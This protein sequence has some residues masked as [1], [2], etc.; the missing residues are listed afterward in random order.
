MI[1]HAR[2]I[3]RT[4]RG[5]QDLTT[6]DEYFPT[7]EG[8]LTK[9]NLRGFIIKYRVHLDVSSHMHEKLQ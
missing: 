1:W 6:S 4:R 2:T 9:T 8:L 5:R 7:L 3:L